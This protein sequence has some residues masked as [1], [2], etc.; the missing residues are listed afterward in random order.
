[1]GYSRNAYYA[2]AYRKS[3]RRSQ[4]IV[5]GHS[6]F[7]VYTIIDLGVLI[8][9]PGHSVGVKQVTPHHVFQATRIFVPYQETWNLSMKKW[10]YGEGWGCEGVPRVVSQNLNAKINANIVRPTLKSLLF[11]RREPQIPSTK[12]QTNLKFLMFSRRSRYIQWPKQ[13]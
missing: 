10:D 4:R 2:S 8:N 11:S 13:A 6:C 3:L 7:Q 5:G 1:M 9:E 12:F